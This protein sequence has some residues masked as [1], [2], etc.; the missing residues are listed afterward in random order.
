[1]PL[2]RLKL[3]SSYPKFKACL[4]RLGGS[5]V[6]RWRMPLEEQE[7]SERE[8]RGGK[9][10]GGGKRCTLAR[11]QHREV[12]VLEDEAAVMHTQS[13]AVVHKDAG[14][15]ICRMQSVHYCGYFA[16]L[17]YIGHSRTGASQMCAT[18]R[19]SV[20]L[21]QSRCALLHVH[22]RELVRSHSPV[23][24]IPY[25]FDE[26]SNTEYRNFGENYNG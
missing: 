2:F 1:M 7:E 21:L 3:I 9:G 13:R 10:G 5:S 15:L 23:R 18:L 20:S 24:R 26:Y 19:E 11:M 14:L 22:R 4:I 12:R 8:E 6:V 17:V 25:L 16:T